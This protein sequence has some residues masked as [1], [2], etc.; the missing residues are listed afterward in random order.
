M[1]GLYKAYI[2]GRERDIYFGMPAI[3]YVFEKVD[4]AILTKAA[5]QFSTSD[6]KTIAHFVYGGLLGGIERRDESKDFEFGDVY[7]LTET[8][9]LE[10]DKEDI[11]TKTGKA[12]SESYAVKKLAEKTN[13]KKE[14]VK[15]IGKK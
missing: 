1:E 13:K 14:S 15:R 6:I 10:G 3:E 7:S 8:L 12:F 9:F 11:I 4:F 5:E 2:L